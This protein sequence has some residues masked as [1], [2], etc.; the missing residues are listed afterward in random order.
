M[1]QSDIVVGYAVPDASADGLVHMVTADTVRDPVTARQLV[2][3]G[4]DNPAAKMGTIMVA[5]EGDETGRVV[6]LGVV[7]RRRPLTVSV[8]SGEGFWL[9]TKSVG[10]LS[11]GFPVE[12]A[13]PTGRA[14]V[15]HWHRDLSVG[16]VMEIMQWSPLRREVTIGVIV[17]AADFMVAQLNPLD[18]DFVRLARAVLAAIREHRAIETATTRNAA[19]DALVAVHHHRHTGDSD[20]AYKVLRYAVASVTDGSMVLPIL[21]TNALASIYYAASVAGHGSAYISTGWG[22]RELLASNVPDDL[23]RAM[24]EAVS[25]PDLLL[26]YLALRR[27]GR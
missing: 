25:M 26:G 1:G 6:C 14:P 15:L 23:M 12:I 2:A 16:K 21:T 20:D 5:R 18:A 13:R 8:A 10:P 17:A 7:R 3:R 19:A 22:S 11:L 27:V 9:G 4:L 24:R